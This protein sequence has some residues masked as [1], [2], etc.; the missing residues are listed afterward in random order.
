VDEDEK[1]LP[2]PEPATADANAREL[3]R[4][5]IAGGGL[6]CSLNLGLFG[7]NETIMWGI[8][9]SDLARHVANALEESE[10]IAGDDT[11][12]QIRATFNAELDSPTDDAKGG[13]V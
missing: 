12:R 11:L 13:F 5:W 7:E 1:A 2:V 6:H 10:G 3:V 4:A 9:L 8:L